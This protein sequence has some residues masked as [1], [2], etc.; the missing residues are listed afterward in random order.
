MHRLEAAETLDNTYIV[1]TSDNGYHISQHR[2]HP[3]KE[4]G[5]ETDI[6]VPFI[7]RGPNIAKN[8]VSNAVTSHTDLAPTFLSLAGIALRDDFDG[9]PIPLETPVTANELEGEGVDQADVNNGHGS[10]EHVG[11]EFWGLA[12]PEGMNVLIST[13]HMLRHADLRQ[14]QV[15]IQ[16]EIRVRRWLRKCLPEQYV[17]RFADRI[18]RVQPVLFRMVHK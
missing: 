7:I 16:R 6:N 12:I 5:Y 10:N 17:Q 3:G 8:K 15:W 11:I 13:L 4:C 14:R 18:G 9:Q 2:M 1:Y